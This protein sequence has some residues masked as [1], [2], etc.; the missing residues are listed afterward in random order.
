LAA[1]A[2]TPERR[3]MIIGA[4]LAGSAVCERLSARGWEVTLL[5]RASAP[6][7]GASGNHAGA[8]H[9]LV[10]VDDSHMAR[11]TRAAFGYALQH[12]KKLE[13][14]SWAQCGVLQMPRSAEE[15]HAQRT[16]LSAL[17]FPVEYARPVSRAEAIARS[18]IEVAEGGV[19]FERAGWVQ[20]ATL[21]RALL[22]KAQV[23]ARFGVEV[24]SIEREDA[25]WCA[26][27][28]SGA[29]MARAPVV[30]FANAQ[31]APRVARIEDVVFRQVRG[32]VTYL[33][34]GSLHALRTVLLR[35]GMALPEIDGLAVAGASYDVEDEDP[36]VRI[37]SHEGN[38]E[39]LGRIVPGTLTALNAGQLAGR[40][41]FR[42]VTRDRLPMLG[43]LSHAT[44]G[45]GLY[46]AFAYASRGILWSSL[47]AEILASALEG[48]PLPVEARLAEAIDPGRFA[49]RAKR[50][51]GWP[52]SRP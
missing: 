13:N 25:G 38:L 44:G 45:P 23:T 11:L 37:D 9:P 7:Q 41:G 47:M 20:P 14:V 31:D 36:A 15:A 3:A 10:T 39:R 21:V 2:S 46:G 17:G 35:G 6:A 42:S 19:W 24:K 40:V 48:E 32:Q 43:P 34:R 12:W 29:V 1:V 51:A 27:D 8:F 50:A 30:V 18:G 52:D 33:P 26:R 22:E 4:G 49:R 28:D 16:A 5:E